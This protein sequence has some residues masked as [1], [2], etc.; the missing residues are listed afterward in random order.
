MTPQERYYWNDRR[1]LF[2]K[3]ELDVSALA[4]G[5]YFIQIQADEVAILKRFILQ[6][7]NY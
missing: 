5:I 4:N 6:K 3:I 2:H 1:N 7:N